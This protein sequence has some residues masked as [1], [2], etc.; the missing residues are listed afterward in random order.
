MTDYLLRMWS[1]EA[2]VRGL[3]CLS[4][5]LVNE[6]A[7]RH[8]TSPV[9]TAALGYGLTAAALLG[10][11]L[12]SHQRVA[13]KIEGDGPLRKMVLEADA[14][15]RVL[16]YVADPTVPW[17]LPIGPWD[18]AEALGRNGLLTVVK[19]LRLKNLYQGMISLE[20]GEMEKEIARYL[21]RSEQVAS[22][23]ELGMH[24]DE[25]GHLLAAGGLLIQLL[26]GE[27][28]A[29]LR[30]LARRLAE[31]PPPSA[32]LAAGQSPEELLTTLF[33]GISYE[34]LQI[35]P[36]EFHCTCS[37]ERSRQAIKA[38]G[39][40]EIATLIAEGEAVVDCHFCHER[41][42]FDRDALEAIL[43]E[44]EEA[45]LLSLFDEEEPI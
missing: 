15:G 43:D 20:T 26:P 29:V 22:L 21:N 7:R 28:P 11:L 32:R 37:Y 38:L 42:V 13:L 44:L 4:T 3:A 12:K 45:A 36:I 9:A 19:D 2:G 39:E 27:E 6:A 17:P 16:G 30:D 35:Q 41:Y 5:D 23:V 33:A 24:M 8:R 40:D 18:V 10:A 14:S 25:D 1:E 34:V 31:L